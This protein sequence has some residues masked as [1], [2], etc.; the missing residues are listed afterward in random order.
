M[1]AGSERTSRRDFFRGAMGLTLVVVGASGC[2]NERVP[3]SCGVDQGVTPD[4]LQARA[5]LGYV[6]PSRDADRT[7]S[8][9]QQ[10]V[11]PAAAGACGGC[12]VLKG[13]IHPHGSCRAFAPKA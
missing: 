4:D 7:C 11:T 2:S 12:K 10:Y 1:N 13:A 6:E 9:C 8:R 5:T 3:I